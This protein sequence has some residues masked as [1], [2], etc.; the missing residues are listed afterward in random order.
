VWWA[1]APSYWNSSLP[2][3]QSDVIVTVALNKKTQLILNDGTAHRN[4]TFSLCRKGWCN[5]FSSDHYFKF[6]ILTIQPSCPKVYLQLEAPIMSSILC[7]SLPFA[8]KK[9]NCH[10]CIISVTLFERR[11]F[12]TLYLPFIAHVNLYIWLHTSYFLC[13]LQHQYCKQHGES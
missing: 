8:G 12:E 6:W 13:F 9:T 2:T 4:V 3:Y 10:Y 5:G 7:T 11:D 1:V